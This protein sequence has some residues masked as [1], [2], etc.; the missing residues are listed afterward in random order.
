MTWFKTV[1]TDLPISVRRWQN[2]RTG[3]FWLFVSPWLLGFFIFTLA[4][5][6]GSFY[7]S[8]STY[9]IVGNPI[10]TGLENYREMVAD[11]LVVKSMFNTLTY[12][13]ASVPLRIV[14][15]LALALLLNRPMR[16]VG[17]FR[18]AYYMPSLIPGV[19]FSL[20]WLLM[21]DYRHGVLN[22]LLHFFHIPHVQWLTNGP[23]A[24]FGLV[25][26]SMWSVGTSM[27]VFLAALQ[28]IPREIN[29]AAI[30]DG[31][32]SAQ[33]LRHIT[34][35]LLS[36]ALIF[37]LTMNLISGLQVFT[38]A[39]VITRGGPLNATLFYLLYLYRHAFQFLH[40]GYAAAMAWVLFL[41]TLVA[42]ACVLYLS[43][44]WSYE[45]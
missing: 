37:S 33:L 22:G 42:T 38:P 36:P 32:N 1:S 19:T 28:G 25:L 43:R 35:P 21:F 40:M 8:F 4:P 12:V 14:L 26:L 5:L 7:I 17:L 6:L 27:L 15:A 20:V 31:A 10:F 45:M 18:T 24:M 39:Y 23:A 41:V 3:A 29:E 44:R 2:S 9:N 34:I 13:F 11:P 30:I 16:G